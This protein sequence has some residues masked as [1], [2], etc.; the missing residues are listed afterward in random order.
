MDYDYMD[1]DDGGPKITG[2]R[3]REEEVKKREDEDEEDE[4]EKKGDED[5]TMNYEESDYI[6][7]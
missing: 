4:E 1:A 7:Q 3:K 2:P 5:Y 6:E